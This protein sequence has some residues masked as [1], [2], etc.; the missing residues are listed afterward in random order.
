MEGKKKF[1]REL[2]LHT[3][4]GWGSWG[5]CCW[6]W[7]SLLG[8]LDIAFSSFGDFFSIRHHLDGEISSDFLVGISSFSITEPEKKTL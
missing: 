8:A 6:L 7:F 5:R 1:Y 4:G 3:C 2:C